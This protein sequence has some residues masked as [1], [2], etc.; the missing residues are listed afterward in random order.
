[1]ALQYHSTFVQKPSVAPSTNNAGSTYQIRHRRVNSDGGVTSWS[2]LGNTELPAD[3]TVQGYSDTENHLRDEVLVFD[4][5]NL[6]WRIAPNPNNDKGTIS[7]GAFSTSWVSTNNQDT[8]NSLLANLDFGTFNSTEAPSLSFYV[9][10]RG[11][12]IENI[13][14]NFINL[15]SGSLATSYM[16]LIQMD[17]EETFQPSGIGSTSLYNQSIAW[18]NPQVSLNNLVL[19]LPTDGFFKL[20]VSFINYPAPDGLASA[21]INLGLELVANQ[22]TFFLGFGSDWIPGSLHID[23]NL[24]QPD[25]V[26]ATSETNVVVGPY[27]I[28][29]NGV[30]F[31]NF[32]NLNRTVAGVD[33]GYQL[34]VTTTGD[35]KVY[36]SAT[37][38]AAGEQLVATFDITGSDPW[39]DNFALAIDI[40]PTSYAQAG[41]SVAKGRFI[42]IDANGDLELASTIDAA[43]GVSLEAD[44]Y[45]A[46][47]GYVLIQ[48]G[49]SVDVGDRL[50]PTTDGKA[51]SNTTGPLVA[52]QAGSSDEFVLASVVSIRGAGGSGGG[53]TNLGYTASPTDG[54]VTSDTGN[55]ATLPLVDGTNAGLMAPA[56]KTKLDGLGGPGGNNTNL[57]YTASPTDGTVTSDTGNDATLPLVDGTNAGLMEPTDKTK[58]DGIESGAEENVPTDL[59]Y[60]ASPTG[61]TVTSST[62]NDANLPIAGTTDA[63][64]MAPG[65]V[66]KLVGIENGAQQNVPA[67]LGYTASQT[68]ARLLLVLVMTLRFQ[69]LMVPTRA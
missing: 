41:G 55:N 59:G 7:V 23:Q 12:P 69:Q 6:T 22:K 50:T 60:T 57:G 58:L 5:V 17:V 51:I 49:G 63:G 32:G 68:G 4:S 36:D 29:F 31:T 40:K 35:V 13:R 53:N 3:I 46:T 25:F 9:V 27:L 34:V 66:V 62:G 64:L 61:G 67:D 8:Q 54:T 14:A 39:V 33:T 18:S 43:V 1:M 10:N 24:Y 21:A 2:P 45:Y 38:L 42:S 44:G 48:V 20:T 19:S 47:S 37:S 30:L 15:A 28:N 16:G 52:H 65:D 56:D 11:Q 26:T